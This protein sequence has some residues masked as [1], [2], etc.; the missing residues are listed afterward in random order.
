[1][2]CWVSEMV[3]ARDERTDVAG[4]ELRARRARRF[5]VTVS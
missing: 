5:W 1:M 3:A 4:F 2:K